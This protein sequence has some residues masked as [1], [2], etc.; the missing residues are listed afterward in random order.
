MPR[1][2]VLDLD[3]SGFV[4]ASISATKKSARVV[5]WCHGDFER[6]DSDPKAIGEH[7]AQ[8]FKD[9]RMTAGPTLVSVPR[10]DVS[11]KVLEI[12]GAADLGPGELLETVRLQMRR[13][14]SSHTDDLIFDFLPPKND[15]ADPSASSRIVAAAMS[16]GA[17]ERI[18]AVVKA[19]G[20]R[21]LGIRL[22]SSGAREA[23]SLAQTS[24]PGS[25]GDTLS[26][27]W[28][29]FGAEL[30]VGRGGRLAFVRGVDVVRPG[31]GDDPSPA[32]RRLSVEVARTV[33][34]YRVAPGGADV[35][36]VSVLGDDAAA[37]AAA[38]AIGDASGV[39]SRTTANAPGFEGL[40]D[41][42]SEAVGPLLPLL[43]LASLHARGERCLDFLNPQRAPDT[44]ATKRQVVLG[45]FA[46]LII[47]GGAAWVFAD[48]QLAPLD[49]RIEALKDEQ[50]EYG[51]RYATYLLER[52]RVGHAEAWLD[53]RADLGMHFRAAIN[54]LPAPPGALLDE[55][56]LSARDAIGFTPGE[57]V[58]DPDAYVSAVAVDARLAGTV[59]ARELGA[60]LRARLLA[61]DLYSSVSSRGPEVA[62]RFDLEISSSV[63]EPSG[64]GEESEERQSEEAP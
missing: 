6:V 22:R 9:A 42:P 46:A 56:S 1:L 62:G 58:A 23:A 11:V 18:S 52:A 63:A 26:I 34:S 12:A 16:K 5:S 48:R 57:N 14:L 27:A 10:G 51:S 60:D 55:I 20:G 21:P 49:Q 41:L 2:T 40:D 45:A 47:L 37:R 53:A 7:V 61:L 33:V 39:P 24:D 35:T 64:A 59:E 3:S 25:P 15:A 43:G 17:F 38:Q 19:A 28:Q 29:P 50:R 54:Q 31:S 30:V 44:A 36:S 32:A 8:A 13:Q 4:A